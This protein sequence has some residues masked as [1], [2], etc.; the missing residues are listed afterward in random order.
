MEKSALSAGAGWD[1]P[2]GSGGTTRAAGETAAPSWARKS[3]QNGHSPS[4]GW[5]PRGR[6]PTLR[7]EQTWSHWRVGAGLT[8]SRRRGARISRARPARPRVAETPRDAS[9]AGPGGR[10][11]SRPSAPGV[12]GPADPP[13]GPEDRKG[14]RGRAGWERTAHAETLARQRRWAAFRSRRGDPAG[15]AAA[16]GDDQAGQETP[17][18]PGCPPP[19]EDNS[20]V[21]LQPQPRPLPGLGLTRRRVPRELRKAS[22]RAGSVLSAANAPGQAAAPEADRG[23]SAAPRPP[24]HVAAPGESLRAE[25]AHPPAVEQGEG[26]RARLC[27]SGVPHVQP[28]APWPGR[29]WHLFSRASGRGS[30]YGRGSAAWAQL[31]AWSQK[32]CLGSINKEQVQKA[33]S[34]RM[35]W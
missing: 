24:Q 31:R 11:P 17:R 35:R 15:G 34:T 10:G 32:N 6:G 29:L 23:G 1:S 19:F 5:N 30:V 27:P 2:S 12:E 25:A 28:G 33:P 9:G 14:P 18:R 21:L 22:D 26:P 7:R 8:E 16:V 3:S 20:W 13:A 4:G